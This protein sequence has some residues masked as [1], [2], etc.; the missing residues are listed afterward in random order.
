MLSTTT[1]HWLAGSQPVQF[2]GDLGKSIRADGVILNRDNMHYSTTMYV[3]LA[4]TSVPS[5]SDPS[6]S[7]R[8]QP[9]LGITI[10][11]IHVVL[12]ED[13]DVFT[14]PSSVS[15]IGSLVAFQRSCAVKVSLPTG[16][17]NFHRVLVVAPSG[18]LPSAWRGRSPKY[19]NPQTVVPVASGA[20]Q[21][22][23][24]SPWSPPA[25]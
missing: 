22:T 23:L 6:R 4:I 3:T 8:Q 13:D 24:P 16:S 9:A 18:N 21:G 11:D 17:P 7:T 2:Y 25:R 10:D 15:V 5:S 14:I 12:N 19:W 20:T 1:P